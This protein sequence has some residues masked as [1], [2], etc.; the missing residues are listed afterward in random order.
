MDNSIKISRG[1]TA[2]LRINIGGYT[3]KATDIVYFAVKKNSSGIP[4]LE[5]NYTEKT[6][7]YI[8]ITFTPADTNK[9]D[10]GKYFYDIRLKTSSDIMTLCPPTSFE[11]WEVIADV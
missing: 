1:D 10:F 11:V 6:T 8:D 7:D 9:L 2:N 5:K 3:L 4:L